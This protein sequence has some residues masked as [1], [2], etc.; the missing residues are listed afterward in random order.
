M[1]HEYTDTIF[2]KQLAEFREKLA[3][4]EETK[5]INAL[6]AKDIF[7]TVI[8]LLPTQYLNTKRMQ[9]DSLQITDDRWKGMTPDAETDYQRGYKDG[10]SFMENENL[11]NGVAY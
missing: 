5:G 11:K 4:H 6:L 8:G 10:V 9:K 3:A 7:A 2:T 1:S